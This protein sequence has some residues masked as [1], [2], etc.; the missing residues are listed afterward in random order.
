MRMPPPHP[1]KTSSPWLVGRKVDQIPS[2]VPPPPPHFRSVCGWPQPYQPGADTPGTAH[3]FKPSPPSPRTSRISWNSQHL[4]YVSHEG[5]LTE[6]QMIGLV[7]ALR[8]RAP[9]VPRVHSSSSL[10]PSR[11]EVFSHF[12]VTNDEM[13]VRDN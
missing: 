9:S 3:R 5:E 8:E 4:L 2:R 11:R 7:Y 10:T 6:A 13:M 12:P 1:V